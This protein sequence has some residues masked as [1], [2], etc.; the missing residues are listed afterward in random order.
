MMI[1]NSR[2]IYMTFVKNGEGLE[3]RLLC[4][5]DWQYRSGK[6]KQIDHTKFQKCHHF[7]VVFNW[8][9]YFGQYLPIPRAAFSDH[10]Q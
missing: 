9:I 4:S 10:L 7:S 5:S 3:L 8:E 1:I 6:G 2:N